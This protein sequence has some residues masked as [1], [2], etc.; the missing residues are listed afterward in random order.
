[1]KKHQYISLLV[2][3]VACLLSPLAAAQSFTGNIVGTVK[4]PNGEVVPGVEITITHL[5]TNRQTRAVANGEGYYAST[6][7]PV[8]EYRVEAKANGFRQ[9]IRSGVNLQIQQTA[10]VDF[11]LE[12][13][14]VTEQVQVTAQAPALETTNSTIGKVVNNRSI[15]ELPLNTRNVYSLIF[16]TPGVSG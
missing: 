15:L 14:A 8:G 3:A 4:N 10:V 6:P 9:A 11:A 5:Q 16:L 1:M 13:G 12:V 2:L 7:L